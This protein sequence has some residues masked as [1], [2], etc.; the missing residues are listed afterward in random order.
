M[1]ELKSLVD[2]LNPLCRSALERAAELCVQQTNFNVEVEHLFAAILGLPDSDVH[3]ALGEHGVDPATVLAELNSAVERLRRGNARTPAL[4]PQVPHLLERAWLTASLTLG[5]PL[6]RSGALLCALLDDDALRGVALESV[7]SLAAIPREGLA[8]AIA[9]VLRGGPESNGAAPAP[10]TTRTGPDPAAPALDRFTVDLT[11]D[12]RAGRIDP[13]RG[14]DAEIRQVIDVL[15]RRRQNNPILTGEAGVGKTAVVEGFALRIAEGAVPPALRNAAV[16]SLDLGLLQ[17]GAGVKGEFEH[18]VKTVLDEVKASPQPIVLFIDEA[19]TLIGAG[20]AEGQGDA[21]NLLKPALARGELRTI[22]ATTW[23]EYKR[24]VEKDPALARRFQVVKVDE[25]DLDTAAEM[26]RG[27]A[28]GLERHHGVRIM[29]EAIRDAVNLSHRYMPGRRLPDKAI[30]VLDTACARVAIGQNGTPPALEAAERRIS[31]LQLELGVLRRET[32]GGAD[33]AERQAELEEALERAD[34]ERRELDERWRAEGDKV[35]EAV[36][37]RARAEAEEGVTPAE[38]ARAR[39]ELRALEADLEAMQGTEP[40]VPACVTGRVAA[41]VIS[42]WTGIPVGKIVKDEIRAILNL[43]GTLADR[44]V[45]Q[46]QALEAITRRIRTYRASLDDPG[47][48]VGTFLL[49]GPSGVG[50]TETALAIADSLYGERNLVIVNMSE[51]QEAHSV[52]GL[53][54][55]PPGYVGYGTGGVLTEAVR[56]RPYSVVLLDEVEKAHPDVMELFYQ[57]FDKGTLED[58]EGT[59]VDFRNTIIFLTSNVGSEAVSEACAAEERPDADALAEL[60]RPHL[61]RRFRPA[62]LGRLTV[63]PFFPLG[64]AEIREVVELKLA[65]VQR[66]FWEAHRAEL[67]YDEEV[68]AAIAGRCTEVDSGARNVDHILTQA[69]LPELSVVVLE[70]MAEGAAVEAVHLTLDDAGR[71]VFRP[72]AALVPA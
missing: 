36:E 70:R 20:G 53:K 56:R 24:Y 29:D 67:T 68:V 22:A 14:R 34:D 23:G 11:A 66:R 19:H 27:I 45:G 59:P 4:A 65:E 33:H 1:S 17:A 28:P 3:R 52:S 63:V 39:L 37:L 10:G 61:L 9:G 69:V 44:V 26:L 64:D 62:F 35:R 55:S 42:G 6:T 5:E 58:G 21:A 38:Q 71:F 31:R 43:R 51:Y 72:L 13:I 7:P 47:K 50:K 12:A 54:G 49:V 15:L 48:P 32:A 16:R 40:L 18:R 2:K 25:P 30:S 41:S 57:V 46:P 8:G 60:L